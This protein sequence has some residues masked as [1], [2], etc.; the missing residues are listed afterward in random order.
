[1]IISISPRRTSITKALETT[2]SEKETVAR[3]HV[4]SFELRSHVPVQKSVEFSHL[5]L[6][7][8]CHDYASS[9][10]SRKPPSVNSAVL[11]A[12][13]NLTSHR[14]RPPGQRILE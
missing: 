14:L 8:R 13:R 3:W 9:L 11:N 6:G 10:I 5:T 1:M 4:R 2:T 12:P 7:E